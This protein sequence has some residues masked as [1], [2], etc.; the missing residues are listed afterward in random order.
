[1]ILLS[2]TLDFRELDLEVL[3]FGQNGRYLEIG[4]LDSRSIFGAFQFLVELAEGLLRPLHD[5]LLQFRPHIY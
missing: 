5:L 4:L 3:G 1:M 2:F